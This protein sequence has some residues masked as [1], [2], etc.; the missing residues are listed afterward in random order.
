MI[1]RFLEALASAAPM[2]DATEKFMGWKKLKINTTA[3]TCYGE[4]EGAQ[5]I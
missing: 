3:I 4:S 2:L 5:E 1:H